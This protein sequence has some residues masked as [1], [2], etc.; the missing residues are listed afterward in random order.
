MD[1]NANVANS[2]Y[3]AVGPIS[4][5]VSDGEPDGAKSAQELHKEVV[6]E[7]EGKMSNDQRK[8]PDISWNQC[9]C[10]R[11]RMSVSL[12]VCE[13]VC[14]SVG[15]SACPSVSLSVGLPV[16]VSGSASAHITL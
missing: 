5:A 2:E 10:Q 4:V 16:S 8:R 12:S 15:V 13:S 3:E 14:A 1:P 6:A 11:L 7:L 9:Q